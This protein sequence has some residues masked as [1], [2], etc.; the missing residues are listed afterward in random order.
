MRDMETHEG[1]A[2]RPGLGQ[3][4]RLTADDLIADLLW[5]KLLRVPGMALRP[6]RVA[7][8]VL[9]VVLFGLADSLGTWLAGDGARSI[10]EIAGGAHAVAWLDAESALVRL[11]RLDVGGGTYG[12]FALWGLVSSG[13]AAVWEEAPARLLLIGAP[14][15]LVGVFVFGAIAR[16]GAL[17]FAR[18]EAVGPG[19]ALGS[20]LS[21][22]QSLLVACVGPIVV[23][24]V[25][26]LLLAGG[27]WALLSVGG[28]S[29]IGALLWPIAL[30]LG[31]VML[32]IITGLTLG[33]SMLVPAVVCELGDGLDAIQRA[34]GYGFRRPL[35]AVV[36]SA[37]AG[38]IGFFVISLAGA[39][40]GGWVLLTHS[41][42]TAWLGE[43]GESRVLSDETVTGS[44]VRF[45]NAV[46]FVLV[47]GYGVSY[48]A[49]AMTAVYLLMR[50]VVDGQETTDL[51]VAGEIAARIDATMASFEPLRSSVAET[52]APNEETAP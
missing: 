37:L 23:L 48:A 6:G 19:H 31:L 15:T 2:G 5:P 7:L 42:L 12:V 43:S 3:E 17:D 20:T 47:A 4:F 40:A 45:W 9:F 27:G 28:V 32:V 30:V 1:S 8:G 16:M 46:P 18:G 13:V 44:I 49:N 52:G 10:V 33:G 21:R 26:G 14:M 11:G 38:V 24:L 35:R 51:P 50:R 25:L 36:Y 22:W 39:L 34:F 29:I 41:G